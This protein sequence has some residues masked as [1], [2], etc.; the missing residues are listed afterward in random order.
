MLFNQQRNDI[1]NLVAAFISSQTP[2]FAFTVPLHIRQKEAGS[3][4]HTAN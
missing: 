4:S 1:A 3:Q 2:R